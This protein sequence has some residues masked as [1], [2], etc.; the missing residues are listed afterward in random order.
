M[1]TKELKIQIPEG[2]EIDQ[3]KSTFEKIVFKK[4]EEPT[5]Y[6]EVADLTL[7]GKEGFY[8]SSGGVVFGFGSIDA[9]THCPNIALTKE[10]LEW[11]LALNKLQNVANYLNGDWKPDWSD[12]DS[13]KYLLQYCANSKFFSVSFN[14]SHNL[15]NVYFKSRELAIKAIKILGEEEVKKALGVYKG[16]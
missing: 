3:E 1:E 2:Y 5:T 4:K 6:N 14:D 11:L 12:G 9:S 16:C 15:G 8:I 7:R 13:K 10:Q